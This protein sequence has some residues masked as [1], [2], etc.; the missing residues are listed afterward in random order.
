VP[1][2]LGYQARRYLCTLLFSSGAGKFHQ[3]LLISFS[4]VSFSSGLS[5]A[6]TELANPRIQHRE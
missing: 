3:Q 1:V 4:P 6:L 5:Y 2:P